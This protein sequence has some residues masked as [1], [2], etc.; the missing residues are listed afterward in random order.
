MSEVRKEELD[1]LSEALKAGK[2]SQFLDDLN[3]DTFPTYR[4][5]NLLLL[6][7]VAIRAGYRFTK[8]MAAELGKPPEGEELPLFP[9]AGDD[10]LVSMR[11]LLELVDGIKAE[12]RLEW[13]EDDTGHRPWRHRSSRPVTGDGTDLSPVE[14]RSRLTSLPA[15]DHA[16]PSADDAKS[17]P[18][19]TREAV[20]LWVLDQD[21][22]SFELPPED[23][24]PAGLRLPSN[25][26]AA[27]LKSWV[28]A[29]GTVHR[30]EA[31]KLDL[32]RVVGA[33]W[34]LVHTGELVE[35]KKSRRWTVS[36]A[37][38]QDAELR[39]DV[40]RIAFEEPRAMTPRKPGII[41]HRPLPG[42]DT[43]SIDGDESKAKAAAAAAE[44]AGDEA[45]P[46]DPDDGLEDVN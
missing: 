22:A 32:H 46:E 11:N 40:I 37:E 7:R 31:H 39:H 45:E 15:G 9:E 25:H 35:K 41:P 24:L 1:L 19:E 34:I 29:Q 38:G 20:A 18:D 6:A 16:W 33:Y 23:E 26:A 3:P 21:P 30:T 28:H 5:K 14:I 27:E 10:R 43:Q 12:V 2:L 44:A 8:E 4:G 13:E 36:V 42:W 17:W